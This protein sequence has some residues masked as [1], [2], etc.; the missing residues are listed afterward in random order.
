MFRFR[1]LV[2]AMTAA[3]TTLSFGAEP[4]KTPEP[5]ATPASAAANPLF[6]AST[7]QYQA[8]PFDKIA[9]ADFQP[10][11]EEGMKQHI[12]EIE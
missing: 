9:D 1:L 11:I 7:L 3:I 5:A 4:A 12:A 6:K 10:A 2:V 8:P